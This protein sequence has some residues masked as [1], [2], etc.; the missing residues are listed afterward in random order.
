VHPSNY[1]IE[2]F[3]SEV[4]LET[5]V[6][7]AH[8]RGVVV[9][10][11]VGAGALV[12]LSRFGFR[13][14]PTLAD[15]VKAG[16]DV[17]TA[18]ADKLIGASQGGVILGKH[19]CVERIRKNRLWRT[20][21]VGKLTL[22]AAEATLSLFLDE[23]LALRE[24]P[25]LRMVMRPVADVAREARRIARALRRAGASAEVCVED[26]WSEMGSGSL[27]GQRI[28]TKVVSVK[29]AAKSVDEVARELRAGEPPIFARIHEEALLIDPRTLQPGD[30]KILAGILAGILSPG[31]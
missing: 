9:I 16:A 27:P 22:A 12:D 15:S 24:V 5:L 3:S 25:T 13:K 11:D 2:G 28:P 31:K 10:D 20:L 21:R 4:P 30:S 14:E 23:A 29:P 26:G 8:A 17:I 19:E 6:E 7:I 1:Q 18:S